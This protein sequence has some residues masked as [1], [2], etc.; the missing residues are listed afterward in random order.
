MLSRPSVERIYWQLSPAYRVAVLRRAPG[1]HRRLDIHHPGSLREVI[2][3]LIGLAAEADAEFTARLLT[4]DDREQQHSRKRER[5][6]FAESPDLLYI[7]NPSL[8]HYSQSIAGIWFATNVGCAETR[9]M[10]REIR[11]ASQ[12][13]FERWSV[14]G[15]DAPTRTGLPAAHLPVQSVGLQ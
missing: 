13:P 1:V 10:I 4:L 2:E 11:Q 7:G 3:R 5:R 8:Q 12:T 14:L 6:Y 15:I 9:V